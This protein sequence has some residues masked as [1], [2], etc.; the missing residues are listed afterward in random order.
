MHVLCMCWHDGS[1]KCFTKLSNVS[2][3]CTAMLPAVMLFNK[4]VNLMMVINECVLIPCSCECVFTQ[5]AVVQ[6][7]PM[8]SSSP[9]GRRNTA[10][11]SGPLSAPI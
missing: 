8:L 10:C 1:C 11:H 7:V 6:D 3:Q 5:K 2:F 9:R 4:A